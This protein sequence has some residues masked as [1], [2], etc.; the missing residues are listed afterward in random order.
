MGNG[1][2]PRARGVDWELTHYQKTVDAKTQMVPLSKPYFTEDELKEVWTVLQSGWVAKGPKA[3]EF[4]T[5]VGEFLDIDYVI[6]VTNCT[7]A[8]HLA[9]LALG[10]K[11]NQQVIVPDYTFPATAF[12]PRYVGADPI[13]CDIDPLTYAM[14]PIDLELNLIRYDNVGAIIVVHP[15]GQCADMDKIMFLANKYNVPVIE[16]AAC[17]LGAKYK[18]RFAGTIGDIGCFSLHARK[19][20]TTGEGGLVVTKN[21]RSADRMRRLSEFG[22]A[23]TW[24]RS[25]NLFSLPEFREVGYNYK[26]SDITAAIG[27]V[28]MKKINWLIKHRR[29]CADKY[30]EIITMQLPFLE[31]VY[32]HPDCYHIYQAYVPLIKPEYKQYRDWIIQKFIDNE[33]QANIGTYALHRQTAFLAP[34]KFPVSDDVFSRAIALPIYN[35]MGFAKIIKGGKQIWQDLLKLKSTNSQGNYGTPN[36]NGNNCEI[37]G[38]IE[39]LENS[40]V[41][42]L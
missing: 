38:E 20:V 5:R 32:E 29:N 16:D 6:A 9:L 13:L 28:Q 37:K 40:L 19:G 41:G 36:G 18:D 42:S 31:P 30:L 3:L 4:E 12:A 26:M 33:V 10:V 27:V 21:K 34:R 2:N 8:L 17:A 23:S 1:R 25:V 39:P 22:V 11:Q 35:H 14:D 15:F 7:S 24:T